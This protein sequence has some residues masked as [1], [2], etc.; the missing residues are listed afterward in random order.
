MSAAA[1]PVAATLSQTAM[2]LRLTA[3]RGENLLAMVGIPVAVLL[4]FGA[5]DV[6]PA[7]AGGGSRIEALLPGVLALAI[8]ATGLVN[9]GSPRP[10]SGR[11]A[12]SSGWAGRRWDGP[13]WWGRSC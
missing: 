5:V 7:P 12:C 1:S 2:E 13:D 8:I 9:L 3:R 10:T 11:T 4:F 6:L